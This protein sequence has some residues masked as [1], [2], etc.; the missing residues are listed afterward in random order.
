MKAITEG[1]LNDVRSNGTESTGRL[2]EG[3]PEEETML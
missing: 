1:K 3:F 2:Q